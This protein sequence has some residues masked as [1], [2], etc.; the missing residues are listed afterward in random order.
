MR[1]KMKRTTL[2]KIVFPLFLLALVSIGCKKSFLEI[3]PKGKLIAQKTSDYS[4]MLNNFSDL[5][6]Q[7]FQYHQ[8]MGDEIAAFEPY[9]I[10]LT[11]KQ[12]R[13]FK[14]EADIFEN[15]DDAQ[16]ITYPM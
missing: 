2:Y 3:T 4:L 11:L 1:I 14:W 12:Q 13:A 6:N 8:E 10:G 7:F 5:G 9:F 16:E 15:G